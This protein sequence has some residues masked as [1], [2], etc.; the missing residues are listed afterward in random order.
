MATN[1]TIGEKEFFKGINKVE[2]EGKDSKNPI[3]LK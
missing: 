3:A 2:F 1:L